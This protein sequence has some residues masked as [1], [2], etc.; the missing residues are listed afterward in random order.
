MLSGL[1]SG[2]FSDCQFLVFR[3]V[4][5][6]E[7]VF[8][9][10]QQ[11]LTARCRG[12]SPKNTAKRTPFR[13]TWWAT[14]LGYGSIPINTIFRGMNIHLPAILMWTTGVPGFW[15]TATSQNLST[16]GTVGH[17]ASTVRCRW[18]NLDP[19]EPTQWMASE[20]KTP[21][22]P[23]TWWKDIYSESGWWFG[24]W[25]DYF[26]SYMGYIILYNPSHWRTPS[27]S[28]MVETK[29]NQL[30]ILWVCQKPGFTIW[31]FSCLSPPIFGRMYAMG[32]GIHKRLRTSHDSILQPLWGHHD[33][34]RQ[35]RI[36]WL[37]L[38]TLW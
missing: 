13:N 30:W 28:K 16:P 5:Q 19:L 3:T 18:T 32:S 14:S 26:P 34:W 20:M 17:T 24:T 23:V 6:E 1:N 12:I 11:F 31:L 25:M 38:Y 15:H 22:L 37:W 7:S 27:F 8:S 2:I 35:S 29:K 4:A 36:H 9:L 21:L 33:I 10:N